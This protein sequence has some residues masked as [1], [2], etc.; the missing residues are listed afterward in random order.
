MY[1][2]ADRRHRKQHG[3]ENVLGGECTRLNFKIVI[4]ALMQ[5]PAGLKVSLVSGHMVN[6]WFPN[7]YEAMNLCAEKL[8]FCTTLHAPTW[9]PLV[10][11]CNQATV[12]CLYTADCHW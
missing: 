11:I 9:H 7:V 8:D 4:S 2:S 3:L 12:L 6:F 10:H 1:F 5:E